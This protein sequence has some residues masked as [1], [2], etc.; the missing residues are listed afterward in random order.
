MREIFFSLKKVEAAKTK[1]EDGTYG[2]CEDCGC[3]ISQKKTIS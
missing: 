2:V 3:D 1:I